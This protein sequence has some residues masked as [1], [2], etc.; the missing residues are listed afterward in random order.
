MQYVVSY[1]QVFRAFFT[2]VNL[3]NFDK[4]CQLLSNLLNQGRFLLDYHL[5]SD[6]FLYQQYISLDICLKLA[7][8]ASCQ[9]V[10]HSVCSEKISI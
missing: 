5:V 2:T 9:E 6:N 3:C 8:I 10:I 7:R 1:L 4:I